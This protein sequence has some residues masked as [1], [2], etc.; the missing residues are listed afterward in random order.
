VGIRRRKCRLVSSTHALGLPASRRVFDLTEM[1]F[2]T[3]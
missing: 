2:W 1:P 3:I